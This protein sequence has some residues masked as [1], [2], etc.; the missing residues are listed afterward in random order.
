MKP[1][2]LIVIHQFRPVTGGA[3]LQAERLAA[4][5]VQMGHPMQVLTQLRSP[6]SLAEERLAGVQVHRVTF[7]ITYRLDTNLWP[8]FH[9]LVK[10][11]RTYDI[12]HVQ[13]AFGHAVVAVAAARCFARKC[14]LKIACAGS[15]GDISVLSTFKGFEWG[16]RVLHRVHR[17]IAISSQVEREL[18]SWGFS[19]KQIQRIPNGV[20][21]ELF[22]RQR[23]APKM[24]V[25]RFI[26]IGR[27]HPQKG[28]DT[29]LQAIR[30]LYGRGLGDRF[31]LKLY[32]RD[33]AEYDYRRMA[34]EL[35][36]AQSVQ[37]L[38][39]TEDMNEVYEA[40]HCLIL[41]SKGEGMSNSLL[42]AMS[43]QLAVIA[44]RVSGTADILDNGKDG[45]L[46]PHDSPEGLARN[47]AL[48]IEDTSLIQRLGHEARLK[49]V[50]HFS[51]DH[52]ADLYSRL[53]KSLCESMP[54]CGM[55]AEEM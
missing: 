32:G 30:I 14:I 18:I 1:R 42:E 16:I 39:H 52:V 51:L 33:F 53:Y 41:P 9:Y 29:A 37:F 6:E 25:V 27:R 44:S 38:P 46:I 55:A 13:Q 3:E 26:L 49:V 36:V 22:R 12:L 5:L 54:G 34:E 48:I 45:L 47:M 7:P 19:P 50:Q 31:E 35:G 8:T 17:I 4:K 21:T 40:A 24:K 20:D 11:R 23:P 10:N 28:I 2:G 43:M 15:Y